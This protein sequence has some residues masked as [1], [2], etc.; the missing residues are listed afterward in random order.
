MKQRSLLHWV[1]TQVRV[2]K[3]NLESIRSASVGNSARD[4][5][6]SAPKTALAPASH[7]RYSVYTRQ[8]H[9]GRVK[10]DVRCW[11]H[12]GVLNLSKLL[13]KI[14]FNPDKDRL[15]SVGILSIADL[16]TSER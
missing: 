12:S 6:V 14:R 9:L 1:S 11:G 2:L 7:C 13:K 3:P 16:K 10:K 4:H 8:R 15:W 5:T